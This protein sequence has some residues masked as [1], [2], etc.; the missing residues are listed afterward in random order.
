MSHLFAKLV[1]PPHLQPK[2]PQDVARLDSLA[3]LSDA[4]GIA[5]L[6]AAADAAWTA[7]AVAWSAGQEMAEQAAVKGGG[8]AADLSKVD[9]ALGNL[10]AELAKLQAV[11]AYLVG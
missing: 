11:R 5:N 3:H 2:A 7:A 9:A 4:D 8:G 10:A 6:R 1:V